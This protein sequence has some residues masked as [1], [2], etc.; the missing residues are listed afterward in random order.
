MATALELANRALRVLGEPKLTGFDDTGS[1]AAQV[2]DLFF[3]TFRKHLSEDDWFWARARVALTEDEAVTNLTELDY[4]YDLPTDMLIP[5][6]L[7]DTDDNILYYRIEGD[8][9]FCDSDNDPKLVYTIDCL[10]ADDDGY[11]T[12]TTGYE[13]R[14]PDYWA[15]SFAYT[16]AADL[17]FV[18]SRDSD[19]A[20]RNRSEGLYL[21]N[22][23]A[24]ELNAMSSPGYGEITEDWAGHVV[25][26]RRHPLREY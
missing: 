19:L 15:E 25:A 11:P 1:R 2:V 21:A 13:S 5:R 26:E 3:T 7:Y 23:R 24:R 18:V 4:A 22:K 16:L 6:E 14:I 10:E 9:L 12:L 8:H 20:Q 17:A